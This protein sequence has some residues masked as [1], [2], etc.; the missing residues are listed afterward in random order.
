MVLRDFR[1]GTE[2]WGCVTKSGDELWD[3]SLLELKMTRIE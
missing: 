1:S 2:R 3:L